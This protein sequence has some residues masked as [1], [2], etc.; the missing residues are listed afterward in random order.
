[1][2]SKV[3]ERCDFCGGKAVAYQHGSRVCGQCGTR[4]TLNELDPPRRT[5]RAAVI[6]VLSSGLLFKMMLGSVALAAVGGWVANSAFAPPSQ[7]ATSDSG[8]ATSS[9]TLAGGP[10]G[11][12]REAPDEAAVHIMSMDELLSIAADEAMRAHEFAAATREWADCVSASAIANRGTG[13]SPW[14]ACPDHPQ[15]SDFGLA[16]DDGRPDSAP[17]GANKPERP[18]GANSGPPGEQTQADEEEGPKGRPGVGKGA[19]DQSD[20][21]ASGDQSR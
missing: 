21:D 2:R 17:G 13:F 15:L 5:R 10:A 14:E 11:V 16:E 18:G 20:P 19:G 6:G 12:T 9:T 8:E 1:M 3:G 4:R 7:I